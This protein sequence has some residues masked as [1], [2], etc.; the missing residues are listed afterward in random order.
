MFKYKYFLIALAFAV[1]CFLRVA[2]AEGGSGATY[3]VT[4]I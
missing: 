1:L 2:I 4:L 3:A